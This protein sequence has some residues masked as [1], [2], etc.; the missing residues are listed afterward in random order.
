M[1][2]ILSIFILVLNLML[3]TSCEIKSLFTTAGNKTSKSTTSK[4]TTSQ[5]V[6]NPT[7][8]STK[9]NSSS[10]TTGNTGEGK[11]SGRSVDTVEIMSINDTH[12]QLEE[13]TNYNMSL[14]RVDGAVNYLESQNNQKY[15]RIMAGDLFQGSF[16]SRFTY[17]RCMIEAI[18]AMDFDVMVLGNHEFDWGLDVVEQYFDGDESNGEA[19]FPLLCANLINKTTGQRPDWVKAYTII[20]YY[21]IKVGIIGCIGENEESDIA[22]SSL[23]DYEFTEELPIVKECS[24]TLH[25]LGCDVV[26]YACHDYANEGATFRTI[27][28]SVS[29]TQYIDA[30]VAG[31]MHQEEEEYFRREDGYL[32]PLVENYAKNG[33]FA[34][35][36]L[37][38]TNKKSTSGTI[39]HYNKNSDCVKNSTPTSDVEAVVTRY[40]SIIDEGKIVVYNLPTRLSSK[41]DVANYMMDAMRNYIKSHESSFSYTE[42]YV[43]INT[44][45]VRASSCPAGEL[46]FADM[47][48]W[49]PFDNRVQYVKM[50]GSQLKNYVSRN[51]S[52]NVWSSDYDSSSIIDSNTYILAFSDF[53]AKYVSGYGTIYNTNVIM[54]NML[55]DYFLSIK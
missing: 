41:Q 45:G 43:F 2:K 7:S 4:T 6:T 16:V 13:G 38:L 36:T 46:T 1:K 10:N 35:I 53:S 27:A 11:F 17:G 49:F 55:K 40:Q 25:S 14:A 26:I 47:Y 51:Y 21:G 29:S 32:I 31:H 5:V 44:G 22:T 42:V 28:E 9:S 12:G 18:N 37:N 30:F 15:I 24:A 54:Y 39:H 23:G 20:N 3:L 34:T 33:S 48:E 8:K 52:Y 50:T 19:N